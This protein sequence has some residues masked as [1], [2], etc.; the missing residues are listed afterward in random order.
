[1]LASLIF[2][3][4]CFGSISCTTN[5]AGQPGAAM[6]NTVKITGRVEVYGNEPFTYAGIVDGNGTQYAV[7]PPAKERELIKLQGH[8]IEFTVVF[9][10]GLPVTLAGLALKGG[11]VTP[12]EWKI[13]Q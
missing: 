1:M 8:V 3:F 2:I 6:D 10:D 4:S 5:A 7:H 9:V 11:T 13:I 12:V